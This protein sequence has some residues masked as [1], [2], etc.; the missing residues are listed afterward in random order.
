MI[1]CY[2]IYSGKFQTAR[3]SLLYYAMARTKNAKGVTIPSQIRYV[4]YFEQ[5]FRMGLKLSDIRDPTYLIEKIVLG[6]KVKL[7]FMSQFS[8]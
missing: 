6:P 4:Y 7:G 5:Y 1:C 3:D 2:L 8:T